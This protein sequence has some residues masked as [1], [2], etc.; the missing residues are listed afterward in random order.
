MKRFWVLLAI[1]FVC[2]QPPRVIADVTLVTNGQAEAVIAIGFGSFDQHAAEE[3]SKFVEDMTGTGLTIVSTSAVSGIGNVVL[4]DHEGTNVLIADLVVAGKVLLSES[5]PGGDG[6]VV[7][8]ATHNAV[9]MAW[10]T[11]Y[12]WRSDECVG[13]NTVVTG[14]TWSFTTH[15]L[16]CNPPLRGDIDGSGDCVVDLTDF[17]VMVSEW[18]SCN[19]NPTLLSPCQ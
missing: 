11:Q 18:M 6:F 15:V 2:F 9:N 13:G 14:T 5:A 4:I 10:G 3:L 17:A 8:T 19:W 12:Q 1:S 7:K 16:Q